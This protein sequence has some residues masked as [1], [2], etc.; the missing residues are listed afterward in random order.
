MFKLTY[1][2]AQNIIG[3]V[4]GLGKKN[5][6]LDLHDYKNKDIMVIVGDNATGKST[7]LSMIHPIHNTADDRSKFVVEGKEGL[8]LRTYESDDGTIITTKCVYHPKSDGGHTP[9]CYISI[10]RPGEKEPI[11]MNPNGNVSSYTSLLYTY[12]G[13]TKDYINFASYSDAVS[14]IVSMTDTERKNSVASMIPNTG[15]FEIAY[16]SVNDRYRELRN[17]ARNVAQ[18]ILALRDE[19]SLQSDLERVTKELNDASIKKD[20]YLTKL[21]KA[22]GRVKEMSHGHDLNELIAEYNQM[23][24]SLVQFDSELNA[25]QMKL[26]AIYNRLGIEHEKDSIYFDGLNQVNQQVSKYERKLA[27]SEATIKSASEREESLKKELFQI[28]KEITESESVLFGIQTQDISELEKTRD[29]YKQQLKQMRYAQDKS[30]YENMSYDEV[31]NF[32]KSVSWIDQMILALYEEYGELVSEFFG[33]CKSADAVK[34]NESVVSEKMVML[35]GT[36]ETKSQKRD[37][38]YRKMIEKEQYRHFQDVLDR[39]PKTCHDDTCPFIATALKWKDIAGEIADL[40]EQYDKMGVEIAE[41]QSTMAEYEKNLALNNSA[42]QLINY[43]KASEVLIQK[44][45]GIT[46]QNVYD[47][48]ANSTWSTV[49]DIGVLKGIAAILSEKDLYIRITTTLLPEV[50]HAIE[51]AKVY[52]SN[53][54]M[55]TNQIDKLHQREASLKEDL[56]IVRMKLVTSDTMKIRYIQQRDLWTSVNELV[57]EYKK[58][59]NER[60][61]TADQAKKMNKEIGDIRE[62]VDKCHAYEKKLDEASALIEELTPIKQQIQMDISTLIQLKAEKDQIEQ[63][64]LIVEVI[65]AIIQPGKGIRKELINIYMY[66]IYQTANQLLLNTF[67]GK[68]YLKEFIITDKEFVIP[69]V[70][71]GSE[72]SDIAYASSSQQSTIAMAISLAIIS[73]LIDKYGVVGIDEADKT[74]SAS[75]KSV[76]VNILAKQMRYI[77]ISQAFVISHSP[78]YYEP[79]DVGF[80]CFPGAKIHKQGNDI[81][82]VG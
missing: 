33:T 34:L 53:R 61:N 13:I 66:D 58:A 3:F 11:E 39:R 60:I 59:A 73:K 2:R 71:N 27:T 82:E 18:K 38:I 12:F 26:F 17:M 74:L 16:N 43:I 80:I 46:V 37:A 32:S 78:E 20:E 28:E 21:A 9:K 25:I 76:F 15:R 45:F 77:G 10:L 23:V 67:D 42:V 36:I 7:F 24:N 52:G 19:D 1:F 4:S 49:L 69:Y 56:S 35:N 55:V 81:I 57:E 54:D 63:D 40:K 70:Y 44:Y 14:G 47:A 72:G 65:R 29:S 68:L 62:I 75:N 64:F 31:V 41:D 22:E 6:V 50:E 30:K 8:L 79:F 48:I 5:F 51:L